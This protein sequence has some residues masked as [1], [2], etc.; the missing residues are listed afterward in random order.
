M[1]YQTELAELRKFT[2]KI[3]YYNYTNNALIMVPPI[4]T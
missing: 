3:E 2:E 4:S 1:G